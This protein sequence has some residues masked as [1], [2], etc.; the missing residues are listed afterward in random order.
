MELK[1]PYMATMLLPWITFWI[2]VSINPETDALITLIITAAVP[3][4]MRKHRFV[5]NFQKFYS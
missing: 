3:L 4:I 1:K 2:A 5:V